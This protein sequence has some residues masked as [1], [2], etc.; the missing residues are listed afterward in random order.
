MNAF[1]KDFS[2][3]I[4]D[5]AV[6]PITS[7]LKSSG[8]GKIKDKKEI[9]MSKGYLKESLKGKLLL[10]KLP[11]IQF[12]KDLDYLVR[13]PHG[14]V[15]QTTSAAFPQLYF[16]ELNGNISDPNKVISADANVKAAI[17]K[18]Q[19]MQLYNGGL[20]YWQGG[21]YESWWGTVY[22]GH[23]LIEASKKGYEVDQDVLNR[24][25]NYLNKKVKDNKLIEYSYFSEDG[26]IARQS[27]AKREIVY[28]LYL[29]ALIKK[30]DL[31]TMNYYKANLSTLTEDSKYLLA[32][33][34]KLAKDEMS[35]NTILPKVFSGK[36]YEKELAGSF[37]SSIRDQAISLNT[38]LETNPQST[39]VDIIAKR[40]ADELRDSE[41][42]ST[43]ERA[44]SLLSLGK[45][46]KKA[47]SKNVIATITIDGKKTNFTGKDL[48]F[49]EEAIGKKVKI[50]VS[51]DGE[52]YY[53]WELEGL[54]EN[55]EYP[56][57][58][59]DLK[60][61]RTFYD[62]NGKQLQSNTFKQGDLVVVELSISSTRTRLENVVITDMLPAGF[63]IENPRLG[64]VQGMNW[65]DAKYKADHFDF[66]DDRVN[67]FTT[68]T[69]DTK[70]FYYTVRAV[71]KGVF[72]MGPV[73]ADAMYN[74]AYHSYHGAG[75]IIV[76]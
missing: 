24:I 73:S 27:Y 10:S 67:L 5:I 13:Y 12:A 68:A 8:T 64:A 45:L 36:K 38:L 49:T 25:Y 43:Q 58:D 74:G 65:V 28:S 6:R 52:L 22:A 61:R 71:S 46:A 50:E 39:Q 26:S 23:F 62:R 48:L 35:Y 47:K 1:G 29:L 75:K 30:A 63:E 11:L 51:D 70:K 59:K 42:L 20:S 55:G 66:R 60:V 33:A 18:L 7:L 57:E 54:N 34:Y 40:L 3:E 17:L 9:D 76:E 31:S 16:S 4:I 32:A 21:S 19:S 15:E 14:C 44:W 37:S 53:F 2:P 72:E 56:Q 41:Y 69:K